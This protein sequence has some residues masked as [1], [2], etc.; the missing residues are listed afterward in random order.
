MKKLLILF[1]FFPLALSAQETTYRYFS[2]TEFF[3]MIEEEKDSVFRFENAIIQPDLEKDS[4]FMLKSFGIPVREEPLIVD[5]ELILDNVHFQNPLYSIP[6]DYS[7]GYL[8]K[9]HFTKNVSIRNT[10]ALHFSNCQFDG[11]VQIV[12]TG[13]FC[14]L[15]DQLEQEQRVIDNIRIVN[16]EFRQGLS[17]FFNCTF[18]QSKGN[19]LVQLFENVFWPNDE[20]NNIRLR[21]KTSLSV[22]GH[23]FGDF[24]LSANEFKEEG[25]VLLMTSG[26]QLVVNENIFGN[27]LLNLIAGRPNSN[28][29]L[30]IEK[31]EISK[32]VIFQP[33]GYS[34]NQIIEFSQ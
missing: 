2:Y 32:K 13:F 21:G 26:N 33:I 17:L 14:S 25:F 15:L 24:Y 3:K 18:Q 34:P 19:T 16:S 22:V 10:A 1:F 5:K 28:F 9:I 8:A 20:D 4:L 7:Q 31:N 27:S 12:G 30:V 23:Q 6:G 11:S 29:S